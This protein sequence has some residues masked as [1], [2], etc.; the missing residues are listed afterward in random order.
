MLTYY[1]SRETYKSNKKMMKNSLKESRISSKYVNNNMCYDP[2]QLIK[3][4]LFE[5][6]LVVVVVYKLYVHIYLISNTTWSHLI[7][8]LNLYSGLFTQSHSPCKLC[9]KRRFLNQF[10]P[11]SLLRKFENIRNSQNKRSLHSISRMS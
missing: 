5:K 8:F 7:K 2:K 1:I 3:P 4:P 6:G 10:L 9:S 11:F